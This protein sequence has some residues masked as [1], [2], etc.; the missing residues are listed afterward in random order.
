[1]ASCTMKPILIPLHAEQNASASLHP[2]A[3]PTE[4]G[5]VQQ[6]CP[7]PAAVPGEPQPGTQHGLLGPS[8]C[9]L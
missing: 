2:T 5:V 7:T 4:G 3:V 8:C 1:M 9:R 6:G